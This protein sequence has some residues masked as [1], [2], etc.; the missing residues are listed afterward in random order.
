MLIVF[1]LVDDMFFFFFLSF[2]I[3]SIGY[4]CIEQIYENIYLRKNKIS[5][6][7]IFY[8]S[9]KNII[10]TPFENFKRKINLLGFV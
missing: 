8:L 4:G 1:V 9:K 3:D 6:G 10:S 2:V 5:F 7:L